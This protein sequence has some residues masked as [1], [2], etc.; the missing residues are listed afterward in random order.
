MGTYLEAIG[1]DTI[2]NTEDIENMSLLLSLLKNLKSDGDTP[3]HNRICKGQYT[4]NDQDADKLG[5]R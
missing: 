3:A 2:P 1:D 5:K 4:H